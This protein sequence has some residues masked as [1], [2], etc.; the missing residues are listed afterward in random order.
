MGL[1]GL[2]FRVL[3]SFEILR[4]GCADVGSEGVAGCTQGTILGSRGP[5]PKLIEFRVSTLKSNRQSQNG[6][7]SRVPAPF[8]SVGGVWVVLF[9]RGVLEFRV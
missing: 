8:T 5:S 7:G 9:E 2:G 3:G 6:L 1:K 4:L